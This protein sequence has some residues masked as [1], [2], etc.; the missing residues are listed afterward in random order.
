MATFVTTI[1]QISAEYVQQLADIPRGLAQR[2]TR[3]TIELPDPV[4]LPAELENSSDDELT[5]EK[6]TTVSN[7]SNVAGKTGSVTL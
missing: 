5:C 3:E 4:D 7:T 1:K 6:E 2:T